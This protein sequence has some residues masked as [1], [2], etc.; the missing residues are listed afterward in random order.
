VSSHPNPLSEAERR[1]RDATMIRLVRAG[2]PVTEVAARFGL[3][4]RRVYTICRERGLTFGYDGSLG[5]NADRRRLYRAIAKAAAEGMTLHEICTRL[6]TTVGVVQR[7]CLKHGTKPR[8]KPNALFERLLAARRGARQRLTRRA[9]P[10]GL[11]LLINGEFRAA[12]PRAV[13]RLLLGSDLST[14]QIARRH[15]MSTR[16]VTKVWARLSVL[17]M[18]R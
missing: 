16:G 11:A 12:R 9:G 10:G 1:A 4:T 5:R 8:R 3:R 17:S 14:T 2:S 13:A 15:G 7:A 18:R 6:Q